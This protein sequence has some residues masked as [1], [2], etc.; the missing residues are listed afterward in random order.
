[1]E[2]SLRNPA[3]IREQVPG[4]AR[5]SEGAP[6][7]LHASGLAF[8]ERHHRPQALGQDEALGLGGR[9]QQAEAR[10][11]PDP[12]PRLR[13]LRHPEVQRQPLLVRLRNPQ[14]TPN[15]YLRGRL[16][17]RARLLHPRPDRVLHARRPRR[18][19]GR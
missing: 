9:V 1:M 10:D 16:V 2:G 3:D 8:E 12:L 15:R 11:R 7:Q 5:G 17:Q 18:R 6:V 14:A 19:G 13:G 4:R